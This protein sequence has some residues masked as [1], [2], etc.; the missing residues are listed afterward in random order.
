RYEYKEQAMFK[1]SMLAAAVSA[2]LSTTFCLAAAA[3]PAPAPRKTLT[4][5]ANDQELADTL[6]RWADEA[7]RKRDAEMR[8]LSG[9]S[10]NMLA[11]QEAASAPTVS[12]ADKVAEADSVTNVQHAG[13]DE[14]GI[15]KVH[16]DFLVVLR[17]GRLFTVKIGD[18][19]LKPVAVLDAFG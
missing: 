11:K 6:R 12:V 1:P 18:D 5:F 3:E 15:V 10:G 2:V 9:A 14:G 7:R 17:R 13:V 19:Q 16:D 4:A 8:R